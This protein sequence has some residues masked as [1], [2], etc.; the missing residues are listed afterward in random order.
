MKHAYREVG[1]DPAIRQVNWE[2]YLKV[3]CGPSS[4]LVSLG[5]VSRVLI[6]YYKS[7]NV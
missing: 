7:G 3:L 4:S 2:D 1:R 5:L 6:V